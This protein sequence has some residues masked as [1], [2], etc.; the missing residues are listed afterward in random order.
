[1]D[2]SC[3]TARAGHSSATRAK[4]SIADP[5]R[6]PIFEF[7][8]KFLCANFSW[9][10]AL[11]SSNR[12]SYHHGSTAEVF[13]PLSVYSTGSPNQGEDGSVIRASEFYEDGN[14]C[15]YRQEHVESF[16]QRQEYLQGTCYERTGLL[17]PQ[18]WV[19]DFKC[20][21]SRESFC[22]EIFTVIVNV[23]CVSKF[24][25]QFLARNKQC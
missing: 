12:S 3:A 9:I 13:L 21:F 11:I 19:E 17:T 6:S 7:E 10:M 20:A 4:G 14:F 18:R 22:F 5:Y 24:C 15:Q 25:E 16:C 8:K 2:H 23:N 1:M